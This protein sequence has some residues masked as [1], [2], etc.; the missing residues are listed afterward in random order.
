[1]SSVAG[2][3]HHLRMSDPDVLTMIRWPNIVVGL[4]VLRR[5]RQTENEPRD[6]SATVCPVVDAGRRQADEDIY[7]DDDADADETVLRVLAERPTLYDEERRQRP[8]DA[9]DRTARTRC[10]G[11]RVEQVA[12]YAT[13]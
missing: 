9:E 6:Q 11:Y 8:D 10:D 3:T 5:K 1:M 12:R 7:R 2:T 13:G 4:P